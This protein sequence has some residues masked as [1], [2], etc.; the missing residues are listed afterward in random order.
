M[1]SS[2]LPDNPAVLAALEA[3]ADAYLASKRYTDAAPLYARLIAGSELRLGAASPAFDALLERVAGIHKANGNQAEAEKL[4]R[5][6]LALREGRPGADADPSIPALRLMLADLAFAQAR[7][8]DAATDYR[9]LLETRAAVFHDGNVQ[10]GVLLNNLGESLRLQGKVEEAEACYLRAIPILRNAGGPQ[11]PELAN[12]ENN[13]GIALFNRKALAEA[14]PHLLEALRIREQVL[15]P[16]DLDLATSLNN[17]ASLRIA[18]GDSAGAVPL[19]ERA[20][21]IA[22]THPQ[23]AGLKAGI[24]RMLDATRAT[25]QVKDKGGAQ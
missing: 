14:E 3:Q 17:V 8:A 22:D 18:R 16:T 23:G 15:A 9:Y 19:L 5:R 1:C 13:Y 20:R 7:Y 25:G 4:Y 10:T 6:L 12:T 2:D 11:H 24:R 21:A